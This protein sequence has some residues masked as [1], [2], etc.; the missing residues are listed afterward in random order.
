LMACA[1]FAASPTTVTVTLPHAVTVGSAT[2]PT[3]QYTISSVEMSDGNEYFVVRGAKTA[4][5]T[6]Q[7]QRI[8]AADSNKTHVIF[9]RDGESW[10]F[11]KLFL[12]GD[13]TAYEFLK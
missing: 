6:L 13:G 12:E 4:P 1:L 9:S 8:D 10:H 7:A 11:G 2:L 5:V 3:G